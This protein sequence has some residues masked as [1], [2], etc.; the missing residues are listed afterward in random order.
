MDMDRI[1]I[2]VGKLAIMT[3]SADLA[4]FKYLTAKR[5]LEVE[6][7]TDE[8]ALASAFHMVCSPSRCMN[9][10]KGL[11]SR[12]AALHGGAPDP[13][14][15]WEPIPDLCTPTEL[16]NLREAATYVDV[17][18]PNGEE[19]AD[20]F[21]SGSRK[22]ERD[23]MVAALL[24]R[25]GDRPRQTVV[26]RDGADGSR[27]Y[28]GGKTLHFRAYH[29]D[30]A[31]VVDPTGGGNTYLGGVAMALSGM[32]SPDKLET[33]E[34]LAGV[35]LADTDTDVSAAMVTAVIHATVGASYA[36]EQVGVPA[37]DTSQGDVWNS[38]A[39]TERYW[40]YLQREKSYLNRQLG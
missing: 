27:L 37:L 21:A 31:R 40:A 26:V 34:A 38:Q 9:I 4:D 32:I 15:V 22:L 13:I 39:Y 3:A 17:I 33:L 11:R 5:R 6:S 30:A 19:L 35:M 18:S 8:Q 23:E 36:I 7:L 10:V 25:C 29:L 28:A 16:E 12:R 24:A 2:E 1:N 14:I 20:F